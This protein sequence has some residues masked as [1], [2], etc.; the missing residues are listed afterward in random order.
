MIGLAPSGT[1]VTRRM[2]TL[3]VACALLPVAAALVVAYGQVH[4]ALVAQRITQLREVAA[5]YGTALVDRLNAAEAVARSGV[6]DPGSGYFRA[7]VVLEG[8]VRTLF[9]G[10]TQ[11]PADSTLAALDAR[12]ETRE[13]GLALVRQEN[14]ATAVWLVRKE[15]PRRLLLQLDPNYLWPVETLPYLTDLCVLAPDGAPMSCTR[16]PPQAG[17]K[18][19]RARLAFESHGDLVWEEDGQRR[20]VGFNEVFLLGRFGSGAWAIVASQPEVHA[21][22]PVKAVGRLVVPI[23]VL[24]VLLAALVGVVQVRRA[25]APLQALRDAAGRIG[26]GDF[27]V[28]VPAARDDEFG[29]LGHAFNTMS[30]RLGRQFES[31]DANAEIDAVILSGGDLSRIVAIVLRRMAEV[32]PAKRHCLVLPNPETPR[33]YTIHSADGAAH[34]P[35]QEAEVRRLLSAPAGSAGLPGIAERGVFALPIAVEKE[36]AGALVVFYDGRG[37]PAPDETAPLLALAD[38]VAVAIATA[39]RG[40]ELQRRAHYDFLTQLPNRLL[41]QEELARAVAAAE[42]SHRLLAVLFV[43]L[44][45]FSDVNDSAGHAAGDQL[46]VQAAG[47]LRRCLRR[48]DMVARLGG[49]EFAVVLPEIRDAADAAK[50]AR[51]I[52]E[53]LSVPFQVGASV[54]LSAG[55]G[56][57]LYPADGASAEE[58]LRHADLAMYNAKASGRGQLA[59][60]E[61]SMT[62]DIRRRIELERDL[63]EALERGHFVLHYQPQLDLRSGR[64]AGAEALIRWMHPQRGLVPPVQFI[65]FAESNGMIEPIGRW[66]LR[67]AAAQFVAWK[68][69]GVPLDFVSVN[70]SPRQM[71]NAGFAQTVADT[72]AEY[73]MPAAC[74]RLEITEGA[75]MDE[76]ATAKNLE[77]LT[78]L[79]TPL[80]LDDFGTGYSSLARLQRLP[81]AAIKID[82]S[83]IRDIDGDAGAQAVVRAAI[84]MAHALDK[85]VLAEGV[86]HAGQ[87]SMLETMGCDSLQGYF[88]SPPVTADKLTELLAGRRARSTRVSPAA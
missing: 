23:A 42:R 74:L 73:Q 45:G 32:A 37:Q 15:G 56:I 59:F 54:S 6:I 12:L 78:A 5:G 58:L 22:E 36:L 57:A 83:F 31:L 87:A 77:A 14:G 4:Q 7:A 63:M 76:E 9:G 20:I 88:L 18:A 49:D 55:V 46:L 41:G 24:A 44:D 3:F 51:N 81:V 33:L 66:A 2:V 43:D 40:R 80:E 35:L 25:L 28:R 65:G 75:I 26:A 67:T 85:W 47:R 39:R 70:V 16:P 53:T 62:A 13:S 30:A 64:V 21:L 82:R 68:A 79:G 84:E 61:E 27:G 17:L 11:L 72:L 19:L 86:E 69:Q 60:F 8:G 29:A 71:R 52:I 34:A 48:S 50:V 1:R 10:A 38:R